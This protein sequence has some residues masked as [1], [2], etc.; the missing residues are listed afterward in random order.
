MITQ[1]WTSLANE[2]NGYI[3]RNDLGISITNELIHTL[4]AFVKNDFTYFIDDYE[5][6]DYLKGKTIGLNILKKEVIIGVANGV[7]ASGQLKLK[8]SDTKRLFASGA[9]YIIKC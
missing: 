5:F 3:D 6:Y 4:Q 1:D 2:L 7:S 9:A 8:V